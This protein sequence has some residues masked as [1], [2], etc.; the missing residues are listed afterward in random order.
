MHTPRSCS[1]RVPALDPVTGSSQGHCQEHACLL[2]E[3][4]GSI[5]KA[6]LLVYNAN[7]RSYNQATQRHCCSP[8]KC[9]QQHNNTAL[10]ELA[11]AVELSAPPFG[12]GPSWQAAQL[13]FAATSN[14]R[15]K[16]TS[17]AWS[18]RRTS[19][20]VV[21]AA[22][23]PGDVVVAGAAELLAR[24]QAA[25]ALLA[26]HQHFAVLGHLQPCRAWCGRLI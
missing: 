12:H 11:R 6:W 25:Q 10:Q 1:D 8:R 16:N 5:G 18:Q 2:Q 9:H 3:L 17:A 14:H 20:R 22:V 19:R 7:T 15:K 21:K 13:S 26:R 24:R 4:C 23:E